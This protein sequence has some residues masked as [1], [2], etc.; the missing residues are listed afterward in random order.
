M[1][2]LRGDLPSG[3]QSSRRGLEC[4]PELR[5]NAALRRLH[6][7]QATMGSRLSPERVAE[8]VHQAA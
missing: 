1:P 3:K 8:V 7:E 4:L 2:S 6:H 5:P